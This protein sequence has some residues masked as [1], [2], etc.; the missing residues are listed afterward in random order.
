MHA[1]LPKVTPGNLQ[2]HLINAFA[3]L[4]WLPH[5]GF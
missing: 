3:N 1:L 2:T 5:A 4:Q